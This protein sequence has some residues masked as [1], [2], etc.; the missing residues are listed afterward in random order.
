M[1]ALGEAMRKLA[2][3]CFGVIKSQTSYTPQN[4]I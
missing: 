3:I 2:Q 1:Q 4:I